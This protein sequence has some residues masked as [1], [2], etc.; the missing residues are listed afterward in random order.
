METTV[1]LFRVIFG[2]AGQHLII[3]ESY[4]GIE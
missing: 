1:A 3:V 4:H 2:H